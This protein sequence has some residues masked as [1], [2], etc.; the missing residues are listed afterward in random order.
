MLFFVDICNWKPTRSFG[1]TYFVIFYVSEVKK[2]K[3]IK[4]PVLINPLTEL[5]KNYTG[6]IIFFFNKAN[7]VKPEN[8][9]RILKKRWK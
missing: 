8:C 7:N 9:I 2:S 6:L 5:I 4:A 3:G 1:A